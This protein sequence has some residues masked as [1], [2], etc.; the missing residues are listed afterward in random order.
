MQE[1]LPRLV[2]LC[3]QAAKYDIP[4]TIDA[5]EADR[6]QLSLEVAAALMLQMNTGAWQGLGFAVQAYQKRAPLVIDTFAAGAIGQG[7]LL[8]YGNQA[9]AGTR[10]G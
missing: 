8:G 7:R 2:T 3:Q 10:L 9:R 1:M 4:L 6:L 5:E